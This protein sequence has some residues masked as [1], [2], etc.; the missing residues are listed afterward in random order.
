MSAPLILASASLQRRAL[1]EGLK[2]PF[3]VVTSGIDEASYGETDPLK[4]AAVLA[5][6]KARDVSAHR[7]G[8]WVIG[9]DTLVVAPDGSLLEKPANR[10][11]AER[12][13]TLQS[14]GASRV[15]SGICL[16]DP[17]GTEYDG[18]S[19]STVHFATLSDG[20]VAWWLDLKLWEGRSGGF[21]IDG[22]GQLMIE[23]IEGDW[24]GIVGLPI[25]LLGQLMKQAGFAL[26]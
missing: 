14:G 13:L 11:D 25:Y 17:S 23:R 21:Q 3:S 9:C 5:A 12:M 24:T 15:H 22:P 20:D 7:P 26:T 2:V 6:E 8:N 1:L 19:S 16:I 18:I 10:A 4:R